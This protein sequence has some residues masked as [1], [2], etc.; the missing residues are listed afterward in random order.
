[1]CIAGYCQ[2]VFPMAVPEENNEIFWFEPEQ[3]G[4]IPLDTFKPSKSLRR[5]VER[6]FFQVTFNQDFH[7]VIKECAQRPDDQKWISDEIIEA[8]SGL[9]QM[10][11]GISVEVWKEGLLVGGLYGVKMGLA[12]FG[13]SMFHKESNASKV[14]LVHLIQYLKREGVVLLDTQYTT[15]HLISMGAIEISQKEYLARLNKALFP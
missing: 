10:G 13:E 5:L 7:Q 14:A 11:L 4:I 2:G 1:M 8:Y 6:G 15:P 12:F 9:H 3:R